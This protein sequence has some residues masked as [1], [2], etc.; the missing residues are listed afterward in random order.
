MITKDKQKFEIVTSS[1]AMSN[2][3]FVS[4]NSTILTNFVLKKFNNFIFSFL[5]I[6][7]MFYYV[8]PNMNLK[9]TFGFVQMYTLV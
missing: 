2:T 7:F 6:F 4:E 5:S 1:R 8:H 9:F 3:N